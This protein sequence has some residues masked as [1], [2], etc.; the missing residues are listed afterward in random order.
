MLYCLNEVPEEFIEENQVLADSLESWNNF[1]TSNFSFLDNL[2]FLPV[3]TH[4]TDLEDYNNDWY[5]VVSYKG[6][7]GSENWIEGWTLLSESF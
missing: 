6:A 4:F 7:F 1:T 2:F 3:T 5:E